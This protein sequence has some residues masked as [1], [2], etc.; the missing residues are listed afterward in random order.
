MDKIRPFSYWLTRINQMCVL[1]YSLLPADHYPPS[2][3]LQFALKHLPLHCTLIHT[4]WESRVFTSILGEHCQQKSWSHPLPLPG[5]SFLPPWLSSFSLDVCMENF[6]VS[7]VGKPLKTKS[8]V[9]GAG[10]QSKLFG[11]NSFWLGTLI[12]HSLTSCIVI[13]RI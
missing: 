6:T 8:D 10:G 5:C 4:L 3:H 7:S 13:N 9:E 12:L 1:F 2:D 11:F